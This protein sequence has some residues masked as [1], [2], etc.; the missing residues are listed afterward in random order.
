MIRKDVKKG[1]DGRTKTHIRVVEGYRPGPGLPP[2]QRTIKSFGYLEDQKD[3]ESFMDMVQDFDRHH[4]VEEVPLRIEVPANATMYH[5]SNRLQ[6]YGY[7]FLAAIYE[8]L[9]LEKFIRQHQQASRF[10]G[11]YDPAA[12]FK[13]LVLLRILH[14]NSK[15]ASCQLKNNFYGMST[16]FTLQDIYRSLNFFAGFETELQAHLNRQVKALIGRDL[17][18]AFYD[19]TNYFFETD[20]PDEEGELRQ[21]GVSKEHRVD[22][23]VSM[24]LFMDANGL[25]VSM[26]LFPGNTSDTITLHPMIQEI[27]KSYGLGRL[28]VV[29]DK[30]ITSV[31]NMEE[32]LNNGDGYVLSQILRG[33]KGQRY[34]AKLLDTKA[35]HENQDGTYRYQLFTED[36]LGKDRE[37]NP[38]PRKR[39]VLLYWSKAEADLAR[40]KREEKLIRAKRRIQNQVYGIKKGAEEYIR[41]ELMDPPTGEMLQHVKKLRSVDFQKAADD[42]RF[43]GYFAIITSEL[44]WE[45]HKIREIY[46]G[47]WRIEQSFR[48]LKSDLYARPVFVWKQ[49]HIRAHFL[50]CFTALLIVRILQYRMGKK[51]LSVER[52]AAA[53]TAANCRLLKHGLVHLE[54]VGGAIA[55]QKSIN[56]KGEEVDTLAYSKDDEIALD[57]RRIQDTFGTEFYEIYPRQEHFNQFLK[58]IRRA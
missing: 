41:E 35:Y 5:E 34:H 15:R 14:P 54:D 29:A 47:L 57:Y 26:A 25:P 13:Y 31:N 39:K 11:E 6:N 40:R 7:H 44:E 33:K 52:I 16:P 18:Y 48:I 2:K 32:M 28:I 51:A 42:A 38:I 23:I 50:I 24:G 53:L 21:R 56:A 55:F 3:P 36:Y 4:R 27:K 17:S 37:G 45:E 22:P 1:K 58:R 19:L 43:D 46:H 9:N 30:G 20:F 12:I 8:Q 49:E 10:K